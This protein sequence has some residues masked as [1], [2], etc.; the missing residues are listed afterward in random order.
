RTL[1]HSCLAEDDRIDKHDVHHREKGR[2]PGDEFGANIGTLLGKP[3]ISL[4]QTGELRLDFPLCWCPFRLFDHVD[5]C[6]PLP[7]P[8]ATAP[9]SSG[10]IWMLWIAPRRNC[11]ASIYRTVG[12]QWAPH[13]L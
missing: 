11:T 9:V 6:A 10:V 13:A 8:N 3:E 4:E 1:I 5:P 12:T 7:Q 2:Q